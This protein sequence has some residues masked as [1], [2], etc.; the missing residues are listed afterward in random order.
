MSELKP[1]V[2]WAGGKRK[3]I[4]SIAEHIPEKVRVYCEPFL[5]GGAML[6][7]ML[8]AH[9]EIEV[10]V[11]NDINS[12]LISTYIAIQ[13]DVDN[14]IEELSCIERE[15]LALDDEGR[16]HYYY[17]KRELFNS[18]N[19]DC[20]DKR[21][22]NSYLNELASLFIFLNKTCFNGL[23]REN[24]KGEF[25]VPHGKYKNPKICDAENLR[26]LSKLF[27]KVVFT[28]GPFTETLR[29]VEQIGEDCLYYLDPPYH[30]ISETSFVDYCGSGFGIEEEEL[31]RKFCDTLRN[32]NV[33]V[34][35]S[36][37]DCSFVR[38][39]WGGINFIA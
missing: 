25:N 39:L 20:L 3:L 21:D 33:S 1:F 34:L 2:K 29:G 10:A 23:Y 15:Y 11:G 13:Q 26:G 7:H 14:L 28:Y 24:R 18:L 36:N 38:E 6:I 37:S 31:L 27:E 32:N 9:P 22:Y 17:E 12:R 5:G 30:P 35:M 8:Q 4:S 19:D 16:K